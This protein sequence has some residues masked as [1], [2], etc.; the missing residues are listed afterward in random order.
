MS[1]FHRFLPLI[2]FVEAIQLWYILGKVLRVLEGC[3]LSQE[4]NLVTPTIHLST[5]KFRSIHC[6]INFFTHQDLLF[7]KHPKGFK[8]PICHDQE[9]WFVS[10]HLVV[11][12]IE[13]T[14]FMVKAIDKLIETRQ[15]S[16]S[17]KS[18]LAINARGQGEIIPRLVWMDW[19]ALRVG[20]EG[21]RG[22]N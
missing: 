1:S 12:K 4:E 21:K 6:I 20:K 15:G 13:R 14:C 9:A 5:I 11:C 8:A 16:G 19:F 22:I 18:G 3:F 2:L 17:D 7:Q 10:F